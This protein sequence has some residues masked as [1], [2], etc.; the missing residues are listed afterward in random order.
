M[1]FMYSIWHIL[2]GGPCCN[3]RLMYY[4]IEVI[5]QVFIVYSQYIRCCRVP[6]G[7]VASR[8]TMSNKVYMLQMSDNDLKLLSKI[9]TTDPMIHS[10]SNKHFNFKQLKIPQST[11]QSF[12]IEDLM[13]MYR[14]LSAYVEIDS[15][16]KRTC[17]LYQ[18]ATSNAF[19]LQFYT[20]SR[21]SRTMAC[22]GY[23]TSWNVLY[24][25]I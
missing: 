10:H 16:M 11:W 3:A 19:K 12:S 9:I 23:W 14:K 22:P 5:V 4:I 15:C 24:K 18:P 21:S 20:D 17:Y 2:E 1:F 13:K 6:E 25:N 7:Y 8:L